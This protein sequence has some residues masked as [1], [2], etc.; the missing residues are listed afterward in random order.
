MRLI[1]ARHVEPEE[2][3]RILTGLDLELSNVQEDPGQAYFEVWLTAHLDN[4]TVVHYVD[5]LPIGVRYFV[6]KGAPE[7]ADRIRE[8]FPIMTDEEILDRV[9]RARH[10]K[11]RIEATYMVALI[12]GREVQE[13][14]LAE[15]RASL[16]HPSE[17]VRHAAV[18]AV[19]YTTWPVLVDMLADVA[20]RD[21]S[22]RVRDR[23][24]SMRNLVAKDGGD[25]HAW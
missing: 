2:R 9:R 7:L 19:G 15:L 20:A 22:A 23:A 17:N 6:I 18:L 25:G 4:E 3:D 8:S 21:P 24:E 5:D 13:P 11:E 1:L 12:A 14:I 10:E 16:R